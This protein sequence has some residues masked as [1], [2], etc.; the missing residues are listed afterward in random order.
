MELVLL[1]DVK[2]LGKKGDKINVANGYGRNLV[3]KKV[4]AEMTAATMNNLKLQKQHEEKVAAQKLADAYA[5]KDKLA[6]MNITVPVKVGKDG[7]LFGSVSSKEIAEA[8]KKQL[9]IEVDK[10]KI[11]LPEPIKEIGKK[12]VPIKL[13]AEVQ[14][15]LHVVVEG[16]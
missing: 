16:V 4:A 14:A 11:V 12:E 2:N 1:Q 8:F 9:G 5:L 15:V 7:R 13:H 6:G 3:A 10:K